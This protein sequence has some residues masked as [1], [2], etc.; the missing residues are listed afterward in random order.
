MLSLRVR[1]CLALAVWAGG[2]Y[3]LPSVL[4][5][6]TAI[7]IAGGVLTAGVAGYT[8]NLRCPSCD[9]SVILDATSSP[10]PWIPKQCRRCGNPLS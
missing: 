7:A 3:L 2:M 1:L 5:G 10:A 9:A 4:D 8:M 6:S